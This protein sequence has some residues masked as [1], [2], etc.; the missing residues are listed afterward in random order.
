M[1]V[2]KYVVAICAATGFLAPQT[3]ALARE[4]GVIL[5]S[6]FKE[7][8]SITKARKQLRGRLKK[9]QALSGDEYFALAYA[10][11]YKE[12]D[13][14]SKIM[15]ALSRSKC[16]DEIGE[17]YIQAGMHGTPEGF[18]AA[19]R[20]IGTGLGA[21]MYAQMAYRLAGGD[22]ALKADATAYLAELRPTV[23]NTAQ[24]DTQADALARQLVASGRYPAL[25]AGA[26]KAQLANALPNLSWL[27]FANPK[28]CGWS[29]QAAEILKNSVGFDDRKMYP[30]I[31]AKVR[32]PGVA[33]PVTS[34][35][36]RPDKSAPMLVEVTIDFEGR[37]NGL[38]VQGLT[39]SFLEESHGLD[40][41]GIRFTEP[42][43]T[44]TKKLSQLG[45]VVNQAGKTRQQVD[46]R[47][48]YGNIDGVITKV[49]RKGGETVF[50]CDEVYYASYGD[51]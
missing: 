34:R 17:Y 13:G 15:N 11:G 23:S 45:F 14:P 1:N 8:T 40:A 16:T 31:P 44:V 18:L 5:G 32:I 26:G 25:G 47:D 33:K 12:P 4:P 42:V 6:V 9:G 20:H 38:T 48:G 51:G 22:S 41:T 3:A 27:D 10:C 49:E 46:K 7:Y 29:R 2:L 21:Y 39:H 36:R 28:R 19:S 35:V 43:A 30:T 50:F 37:W 24:A